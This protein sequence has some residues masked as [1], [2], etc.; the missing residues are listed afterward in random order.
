M[1]VEGQVSLH[2]RNGQF[3]SDLVFGGDSR[4]VAYV[5]AGSALT[6]LGRY[7]GQTVDIT[8]M[9]ESNPNGV[10][11]ISISSPDQVMMSDETPDRLVTCDKF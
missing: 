2:S 6:D 10:A 4:F 7:D 11:E 1:T 3:G 5:P 8:G 9:I